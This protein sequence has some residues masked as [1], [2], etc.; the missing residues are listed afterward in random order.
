MSVLSILIAL[1]SSTGG[2]PSDPACKGPDPELVQCP[3]PEAP[4]VTELGSG[5]VVL[6][7]EIGP[8]GRVRS[9]KVVSSSGHPAWSGAAQTA[10]AKWRYSAASTSRTRVVPFDF[11]LDP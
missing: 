7:L 6:E 1:A 4:R 5:K 9:S 2:L 3:S 11:Q 8:D 10:V